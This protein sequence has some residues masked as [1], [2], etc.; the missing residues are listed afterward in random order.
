MHDERIKQEL[1]DAGVTRFGMKK[2]AVKY[3]PKIIHKNE[4]IHGVVY[5]RYGEKTGSLTLVEGMLVATDRR[6]IFLDH[7]PGFTSTDEIT[8]DVVSG[9]RANTAFFTAVTLHTRIGDYTIRFANPKCAETFID[10]VGERR[11]ESAKSS[12]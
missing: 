9:V 2:F 11:L 8:Y 3:L 5:G 10:Y 4:H 1:K 12:S 7:K 6:I